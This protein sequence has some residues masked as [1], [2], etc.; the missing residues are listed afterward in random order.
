MAFFTLSKIYSHPEV[1]IIQGGELFDV[2]F[3]QG[4]IEKETTLKNDYVV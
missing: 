3:Y 1:K 2:L 4:K